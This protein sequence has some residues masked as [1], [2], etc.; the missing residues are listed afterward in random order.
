MS[1]F[2]IAVILSPF[3]LFLIFR[4]HIVPF[5]E[6]TAYF[7]LYSLHQLHTGN[8]WQEYI[9][10][11]TL[12]WLYTKLS[13]REPYP[14]KNIIYIYTYFHVKFKEHYK[15][16]ISEIFPLIHFIQTVFL[17]VKG[18]RPCWCRTDWTSSGVCLRGWNIT[19]MISKQWCETKKQKH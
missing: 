5:I 3:F 18:P 17:L 10:I 15:S 4:G 14:F 6:A 11:K 8:Y 12:M 9:M 19:T 7:L 1:F 16:C 13:A 2:P